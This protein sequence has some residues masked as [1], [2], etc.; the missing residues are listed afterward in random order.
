[1][2]LRKIL[3]KIIKAIEGNSENN[4]MNMRSSAIKLIVNGK[5]QLAREN[6]KNAHI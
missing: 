4:P 2:V 5:P 6:N 3:I 1:M